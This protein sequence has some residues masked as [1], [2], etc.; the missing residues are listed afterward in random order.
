MI[1]WI[2]IRWFYLYIFIG[3]MDFYVRN[4]EWIVMFFLVRRNVV[5]YKCCLELF[6]DV[7]FYLKIC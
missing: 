2:L 4:N 3:D 7:M 1:F 5:Y 6:L